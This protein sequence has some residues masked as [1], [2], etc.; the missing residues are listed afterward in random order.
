MYSRPLVPDL[1]GYVDQRYMVPSTI[2]HLVGNF[3]PTALLVLLVA[4]S[5]CAPVVGYP[6]NWQDDQSNISDLESRIK[7]QKSSYY[8]TND[9][10][11]KR[12]LRNSIIYNEMQIYEINFSAFNRRLW[13]DTNIVSAG[14]DLVVL[15]LAG[16]GA[17]NGSEVTKSALAAASAGVVGAQAAISKDLYYQRTLP[18]LLAQIAANRDKV[19][20][21]IYDALNKQDDAAYPLARAEIDLQTLQR[22]SGIADAIESI[23]EQAAGA[24]TTAQAQ[25]DA[26]RSGAFSTQPSATR[27]WNWLF[28]HGTGI[29]PTTG[30]TYQPDSNNLAKLQTWINTQKIDPN[31]PSGTPPMQLLTEVQGSTQRETDRQQAI[32]DLK[33][34]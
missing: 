34:P 29:D 3:V 25:M 5:S 13:G 15:A 18:A 11:Q 7:T 12:S 16:L 14:G 6:E 2:R 17:T 8:T 20:A 23:T 10:T 32:G 24:K 21:G 4:L 30:Q 19:K 1:R 27:I 33:I 22:E 9:S 28:P 31:L 26:A